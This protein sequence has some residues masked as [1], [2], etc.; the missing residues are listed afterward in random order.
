MCLQ[1]TSNMI[2]FTENGTYSRLILVFDWS[3]HKRWRF[4]IGCGTRSA[5]ESLAVGTYHTAALTAAAL[6]P[7]TGF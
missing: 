3:E 1:D 2:I 7:R 5:A 6:K 4:T